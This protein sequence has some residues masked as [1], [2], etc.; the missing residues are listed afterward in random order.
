MHENT[1]QYFVLHYITSVAPLQK[2]GLLFAF[3]WMLANANAGFLLYFTMLVDVFLLCA[4]V[5]LT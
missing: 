3:W 1:V 5:S 2:I 4:N